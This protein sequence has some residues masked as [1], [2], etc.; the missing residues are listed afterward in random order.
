MIGFF[1]NLFAGGK[2]ALAEATSRDATAIAVLHAASFRRGWSAEEFE[3]LLLDDNVIAH[4]AICNGKLAGFVVSRRSTDEAEI[5]SVAVARPRRGKGLAGKLLIMHLRRLS[6][7]GVR[8]VFLEVD[9]HNEPAT[10]L[11]RRAGFHT[12]GR[13]PNYY[14]IPV[15]DSASALILRR[16]L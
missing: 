3:L 1:A 5:L 4:R 9:E 15:G 2:P 8:S 16:D 7:L 6:A 11:Y 13:R 12:V 10:K 14:P